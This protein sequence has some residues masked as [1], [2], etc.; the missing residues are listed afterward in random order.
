VETE[1]KK[2]LGQG[3]SEG[4]G[5]VIGK[6]FPVTYSRCWTQVY[7]TAIGHVIERAMCMPAL[8]FALVNPIILYS[9]A[10][11]QKIYIG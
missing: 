5:T 8:V 4:T 11:R 2:K 6:T 1:G 3:N 9:V 7:G 10:H